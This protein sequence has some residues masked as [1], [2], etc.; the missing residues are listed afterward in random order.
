MSNRHIFFPIAALLGAL[1]VAL[2]AFGAHGLEGKLDP[3]SLQTYKTGVQYHFIHLIPLLLIPFLPNGRF[4][5]RLLLAG[6]LFLLGIVL[7]SGSL[8]LLSTRDL[9]GLKVAWL[10]PVTPIGGLL[11]I[12][13]WVALALS[14]PFA[15]KPTT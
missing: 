2:G 10:G 6:W 15:E 8:Y 3:S 13:G 9:T 4:K 1:A 11:F 7:F 14:H 12:G 5:V